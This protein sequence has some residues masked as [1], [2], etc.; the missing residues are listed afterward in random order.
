MH[1][2][3]PQRV[4]IIT[5]SEI[6]REINISVGL[7]FK[8]TMVL[9]SNTTIQTEHNATRF[10]VT[11]PRNYDSYQKMIDISYTDMNGKPQT[12]CYHLTKE[13]DSYHFDI[14]RRFLYCDKIKIQFRALNLNTTQ[15]VVDPA[16]LQ[17]NV[18][19]ALKKDELQKIDEKP[20]GTYTNLIQNMIKEVYDGKSTLEDIVE[21]SIEH[22]LGVFLQ[23]FQ[24][25]A[26]LT[27]DQDGFVHGIVQSEEYT[28][29]FTNKPKPSTHRLNVNKA[30]FIDEGAPDTVSNTGNIG[31]YLPNGNP[32]LL[33]R[34]CL[35]HFDVNNIPHKDRIKRA[36]LT[37]SYQYVDQAQIYQR[38]DQSS[39]KYPNSDMICDVRD[40]KP[41]R[42]QTITAPVIQTAIVYKHFPDSVGETT[43][44]LYVALQNDDMH[45]VERSIVQFDLPSHVGAATANLSLKYYC[46]ES[47]GAIG[48][49]RVTEPWS[50]GTTTW[51][52]HPSVDSEPLV[53]FELTPGEAP[54]RADI[55]ISP[56][57]DSIASGQE[58]YG[59]LFRFVDESSLYE[60]WRV[61]IFNFDSALESD[62]SNLTMSGEL[63]F[64]WES[65]NVTWNMVRSMIAESVSDITVHPGVGMT[66]AD[67]TS[68][69]KQWLGH[70]N[71]NN[72][73]AVF[74]KRDVS[75]DQYRATILYKDAMRL[76]NSNLVIEYDGPVLGESEWSTELAFLDITNDTYDD[77]VNSMTIDSNGTRHFLIKDG[78]YYVFSEDGD[79]WTI[80]PTD[81]ES[82]YDAKLVTTADG[83]KYKILH[84]QYDGL[85]VYSRSS[86][87]NWTLEY[88]TELYKWDKHVPY[89]MGGSAL[90][91]GND[92]YCVLLDY[93]YTM[94]LLSRVSGEWKLETLYTPGCKYN[95]NIDYPVVNLREFNG[96]L[97]ILFPVICYSHIEAPNIMDIG[98]IAH[99]NEGQSFSRV[100]VSD[101]NN[102]A[103]SGE[104]YAIVIPDDILID[105][106]KKYLS[107]RISNDTNLNA[108]NDSRHVAVFDGEKW[109]VHSTLGV[110]WGL[111]F[112]RNESTE[113]TQRSFIVKDGLG[114]IWVYFAK[115]FMN[116][117]NDVQCEL[118]RRRLN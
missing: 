88:E 93:S 17:F 63:P 48:I 1:K 43:S 96:T 50:A 73:I 98:I 114:K 71:T 19:N 37:I 51:N 89:Y 106:N 81:N 21:K 95:D 67:I 85:K 70:P 29:A 110:M 84:D 90:S 91:V 55:N 45:R 35:L 116:G 14:A 66:K 27:A 23:P 11:F 79:S 47:V 13:N 59:W 6:V 56:I 25:D 57:I 112:M 78:N 40:I 41:F 32:P 34:A 33:D 10:V 108:A 2:G 92:I 36:Y 104:Y 97:Y 82:I 74:A 4:Y 69:V 52:T 24:P 100:F 105:G 76:K 39:W 3:V 111:R 26:F 44:G 5:M 22:P 94:K 75:S 117:Y 20:E 58:N 31:N 107:Y 30:A 15:E 103:Y 53:T 113:T 46:K 115:Q 77:T 38:P 86:Y 80:E 87:K 61:Q 109:K 65:E 28:K 8:P 49:Y 62:R 54:I 18:K 102:V 16:I 83:K 42:D 60:N 12:E 118:Y 9:K 7:G 72:G 99:T 68:T 64:E 101:W